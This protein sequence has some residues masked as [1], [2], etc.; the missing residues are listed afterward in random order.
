VI[1]EY[2]IWQKHAKSK[3]GDCAVDKD[4][5]KQRKEREWKGEGAVFI[6]KILTRF[7]RSSAQLTMVMMTMA[8]P[9]NVTALPSSVSNMSAD[10]TDRWTMLVCVHTAACECVEL[11]HFISF[12]STAGPK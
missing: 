8:L 3:L 7:L 2:R 9:S 10:T 11:S 5:K 1:C 6:M 4:R 12:T